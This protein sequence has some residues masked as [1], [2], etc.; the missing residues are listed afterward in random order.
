[1]FKCDKCDKEF[2]R[3]CDL[4][5]HLKN[6]KGKVFCGYCGKQ[7]YNPKYCN[8][9]CAALDT[10]P[11]RKHSYKTRMK[12]SKGVGGDGSLVEKSRNCI[13]CD[14][15]LNKTSKKYCSWKCH[16]DK[17]YKDFINDWLKNPNKHNKPSGHMKRY[18]IEKYN[19]SCSR[20][21]WNKKHPVRK[22]VP[23]EM[24]HRDGNWR[25]NHPDN[26][27][28]V[29]PNCHSLTVTYR[30]G[31]KGNGRKDQRDYYHKNKLA[32]VRLTG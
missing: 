26:L 10:T 20:C 6:C 2:G 32:P 8:K 30:I 22:T 31:N 15:P 3:K 27:D 12:I 17:N 7:T 21:G 24:H 13:T 28:L 9:T 16:T 4:S 1:M 19:N 25:N 11:G 23:L 14:S 5:R 29:C 18:L